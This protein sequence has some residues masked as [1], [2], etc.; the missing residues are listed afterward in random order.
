MFQWHLEDAI[1]VLENIYRHL[2]MGKDKKEA[3]LEGRN[4]IGF[5]ALSITMVDVVVYGPLALTSGLVGGI[6]RQFALVIV[7]AALM[8]LF[9]SLEIRR[10]ITLYS[11]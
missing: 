9:V 1:V 4:E 8:S 2:E 3:A 10:T 6:M 5:T 11:M 7:F